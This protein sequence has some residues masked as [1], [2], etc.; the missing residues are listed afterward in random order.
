MRVSEGA[1]VI[2]LARTEREEET[3]EEQQEEEGN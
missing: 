1:K 3:A 2:S